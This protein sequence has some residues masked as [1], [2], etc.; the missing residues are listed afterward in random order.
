MSE[1]VLGLAGKD[2]S[3]K[4]VLVPLRLT[5]GGVLRLS[6]EPRV[7][8]QQLAAVGATNGVEL[9]GNFNVHITGAFTGSVRLERSFDA[10]TSWAP[11]TDQLGSAVAFTAPVSLVAHEPE[12]GVRYRANA[13][14]LTAGTPTIRL[15]Q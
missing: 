5:G 11:L 3:G 15:S 7:L 13:T 8:T 1:L 12:E 2:T 6:G 10:G 14:A 4:D 9:F